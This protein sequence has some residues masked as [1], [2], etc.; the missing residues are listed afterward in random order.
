[1]TKWKRLYNAFVATQKQRQFGNHVVAFIHK[2]MRPARHV[3]DPERFESKRKELNTA[4]AFSGLFL[5]QDGD[6]K[7]SAPVRTLGEAQERADRLRAKLESRGVHNDVLKFCRAELV[8]ENYFHAILEA[9][10]SVAEKI[11]TV[12]GLGTD[13]AELA[14]QALALGKSGRPRLSI[15]SLKTETEESEQTGFMNLLVG[16]FGCFRNPPAHAPKI[17]W[18]IEEQDALDILSLVSLVHRKLDKAERCD[19]P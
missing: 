10:K 11:R 5:D 12:T 13:G 6:V 2:A 18:P 9:A 8:K 16:L 1:M 4:L 14:M 15:N 17:Y 19:A 7:R 3:S